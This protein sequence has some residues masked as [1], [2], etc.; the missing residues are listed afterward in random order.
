MRTSV[1]G[2]VEELDRR[3]VFHPFAQLDRHPSAT[4]PVIVE[5]EAVRL[6]AS[7]RRS[8]LDAMAGR[9]CVN[10]GYGRREIGEALLRIYGR[11][12]EHSLISR[13]LPALDMIAFSPP[14]V[15][16]EPELEEMIAIARRAVDEV[17]AELA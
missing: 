5:G 10:V 2:T 4:A 11:R 6:R 12:I 17:A 7:A 9:W 8:Y 14:F 16:S 1:A 13:D 15:V 3:Y